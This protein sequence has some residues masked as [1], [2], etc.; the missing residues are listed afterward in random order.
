MSFDLEQ[1]RE[2]HLKM[3]WEGGASELVNYGWSESTGD[4]KL[5]SLW[6]KFEAAYEAFNKRYNELYNEH[7]SKLEH[8]DEEDGEV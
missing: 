2:F 7:A 8:D 3:E 5:D 6:E 4:G 1:F